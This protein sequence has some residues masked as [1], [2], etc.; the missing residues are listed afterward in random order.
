VL[1]AIP[2]SLDPAEIES[3]ISRATSEVVENLERGRQVGLRTALNRFAPDSGF[4]H[5]TDLLSFLARVKADPAKLA[6]TP[7]LE[8]APAEAVR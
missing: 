8:H 6:E 2:E 1:L 5:R 3:R 4:A 7:A